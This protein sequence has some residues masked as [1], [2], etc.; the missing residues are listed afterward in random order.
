MF[1]TVSTELGGWAWPSETVALSAFELRQISR[2][3]ASRL[4]CFLAIVGS[5]VQIELAKEVKGAL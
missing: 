1:T 2:E 5:P 3:G 4:I